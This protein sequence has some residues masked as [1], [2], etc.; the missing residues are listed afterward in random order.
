MTEVSE[1]SDASEAKSEG[2][3]AGQEKAKICIGAPSG[4]RHEFHLG[5]NDVSVVFFFS[6]SICSVLVSIFLLLQHT[7][8]RVTYKTLF[9]FCSFVILL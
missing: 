7:L 2:A 1:G 4:F 6:S 8:G 3:Q 5:A 9:F